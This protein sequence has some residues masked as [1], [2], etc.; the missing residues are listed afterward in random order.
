MHATNYKH[1]TIIE[2]SI[3]I[4]AYPNPAQSVIHLEALGGQL[5]TLVNALGITLKQG[6]SVES[7]VT[8]I[9]TQEL[10]NGIYFI[11]IGGKTIS[12][13]INH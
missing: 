3:N 4:T 10:A 8:K 7:G 13:S 9:N 12:V 5:F 11:S 2:N 1:N 6:T